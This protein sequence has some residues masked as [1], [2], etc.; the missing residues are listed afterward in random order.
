[1]GVRL[2]QTCGVPAPPGTGGPG[3]EPCLSAGRGAG[4][5]LVTFWCARP[6]AEQSFLTLLP[7]RSE[8]REGHCSAF[9]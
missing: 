9:L 1:M 4:E 7:E 6:V 8:A 3:L 2:L 5:A